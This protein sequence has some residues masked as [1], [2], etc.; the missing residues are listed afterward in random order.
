MSYVNNHITSSV[1]ILQ[2]PEHL[3]HCF[4]RLFSYMNEKD[5]A[6]IAATCKVWNMAIMTVTAIEEDARINRYLHFMAN[7]LK[8]EMAYPFFHPEEKKKAI[9]AL[10]GLN[11]DISLCHPKIACLKKLVV[12]FNKVN[13]EDRI[14]LIN[15]LNE[16]IPKCNEPYLTNFIKS[17][18][19]PKYYYAKST[20]DEEI[21]DQLNAPFFT[22]IE[23]KMMMKHVF[24]SLFK[25]HTSLD[26]I[27]HYSQGMRNTMDF[28]NYVYSACKSF[29]KKRNYEVAESLYPLLP[30]YMRDELAKHILEVKFLQRSED[31]YFDAQNI[32]V[33]EHLLHNGQLE[34]CLKTINLIQ[35]PNNNYK[36]TWYALAELIASEIIKTKSTLCLLQD[37]SDIK[38]QEVQCILLN[39]ITIL[40]NKN[41]LFSFALDSANMNPSKLDRKFAFQWVLRALNYS[42]EEAIMYADMVN[43]F[44]ISSERRDLLK[45]TINQ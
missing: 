1:T 14:I 35:Y 39:Q 19:S 17:L 43:E 22:P 18:R 25:D 24:D 33:I 7:C 3:T 29:I 16:G 32:K 4:G 36:K 44:D 6:S 11:A 20:S 10:K 28:N 37:I 9:L 31:E 42:E 30:E 8:L 45:E 23:K 13:L 12:I 38:H 5:K 27:E 15:Q 26:I 34:D 21:L 41:K 2:D 40:L